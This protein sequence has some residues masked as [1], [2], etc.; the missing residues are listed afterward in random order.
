MKSAKVR[1]PV[2]AGSWYPANASDCERE[3]KDL[4]ETWW[5]ASYPTPAGIFREASPVM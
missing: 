2:F 4:T 1:K 3:I 5:P